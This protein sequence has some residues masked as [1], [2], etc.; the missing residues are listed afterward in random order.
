[1]ILNKEKM[2]HTTVSAIKASS[3]TLPTCKKESEANTVFCT[4][5]N[6]QTFFHGYEISHA[7]RYKP[8][9]NQRNFH[10]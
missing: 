4:Q 6:K 8:C 10:A 3:G 1:M 7:Q 5:K 9:W 2:A